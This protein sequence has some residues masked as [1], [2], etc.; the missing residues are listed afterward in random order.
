MIQHIK[1]DFPPVVKSQTLMNLGRVNVITG[2]NSAGKSTIL[3]KII[4]RQDYG[5][6]IE[7]T[8]E[9]GLTIDGQMGNYSEPSK[10][11][12]E[13]WKNKIIDEVYGK[14]FF[15]T[16]ESDVLSMVINAKNNSS[17]KTYG[18]AND[19][20][21]IAKSLCPELPSKE[22]KPVLL[23]PKRR[24]QYES[25]ANPMVGLDSEATNA[26]SRLFYLKTQLPDSIERKIFERVQFSFTE[27]TGNEFEIQT[28]NNSNHPRIQLQ[29]RRKGGSWIIGQN[30][31][32]GLTE[33]LSIILYAL[34]GSS[35][36]LL[37]EEP[38]NHL[39][40]DLQRKLLYFLSSVEDRQF[41]LST[42]SPIFLNPT[43]VDR[44]YFCKYNNGEI[45]VDDN[46]SRAEALTHLGVLA[47]DNLTSD[48]VV[49]AEGKTDQIVIDYILS[50]WL[51]APSNVS[52]SY[53]FLSGSMMV[54]FDPTPFAQIRNTFAL[55]DF[56]TSNIDAQKKFIKNCNQSGITPTQLKRYSLENYYSLDAIRTVFGDL[57]SS[58]IKILEESKPVWKQLADANHDESWWKGE[59]K[60]SRRINSILKNMTRKD[61]EKTDLHEFCTKVKS[62]L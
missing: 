12:L 6:T 21:R 35:E 54:Y 41:L 15:S 4:E 29:F 57:V 17:V 56:D 46:T 28:L 8:A 48:A 38:E 22:K 1:I 13:D 3:R 36:L 26:L 20:G 58:E 42:H 59:L 43:I 7:R 52:V 49:I 19:A 18:L 10:N 16:S 50:K 11:S 23:S 61:I 62:T 27:I 55:L 9:L 47:I 2:R 34:D 14:V 39:H 60:S 37:V 24:L 53:V 5:V 40:P 51:D 31:G 44:I 25:D 45:N 33:V 32:L 30:D